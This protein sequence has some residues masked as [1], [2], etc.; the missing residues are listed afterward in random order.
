MSRPRLPP[1]PSPPRA[2]LV[3]GSRVAPGRAPREADLPSREEEAVTGNRSWQEVAGPGVPWG[4][5]VGGAP[6]PSQPPRR[7]PGVS[8]S[9]RSG[10]LWTREFCWFCHE[11]DHLALGRVIKNITSSRENTCSDCPFRALGVVNFSCFCRGEADGGPR[12]LQAE[13]AGAPDSE[14][15]LARR[16]AARSPQPPPL[17]QRHSVSQAARVGDAAR[18]SSSGFLLRRPPQG[19][20]GR[21]LV[22]RKPREASG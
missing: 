1:G 12:R 19:G 21:G 4:E 17:C 2:L 11:V 14:V 3:G 10:R 7:P 20:S 16:G 22:L 15:V 18:D 6:T 13:A 5:R 8:A 9:S